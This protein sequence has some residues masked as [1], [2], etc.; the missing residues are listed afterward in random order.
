VY[1][2]NLVNTPYR[3]YSAVLPPPAAIKQRTIAPDT[4][5]DYKKNLINS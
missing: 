4:T 5:R 2:G 1:N 3:Q